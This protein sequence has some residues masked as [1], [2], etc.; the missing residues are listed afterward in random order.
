MRTAVT[1]AILGILGIAVWQVSRQMRLLADYC[2]NVVGY[3][4]KRISFDR[5][6]FELD[7]EVYNKSNI[8]V[9]I[10][11]Y[12]LS[13]FMN[14]QFV[15]KIYNQ[16][17]QLVRGKSRSIVTLT[18]DFAP[19]QA[20]LTVLNFDFARSLISEQTVVAI[21]GHVTVSHR[22][23]KLRDLPV[24]IELPLKEMIPTRGAEKEVC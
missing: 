16:V 4:I 1:I 11:S 5:I 15:S 2:F 8:D 10:D 19:R 7:L 13:V 20:L 17:G 18:I 12:D 3:R 23:A 6:V 22:G 24:D 9:T 21:K 14:G